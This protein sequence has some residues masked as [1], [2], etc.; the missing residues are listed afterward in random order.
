MLIGVDVGRCRADRKQPQVQTSLEGESGKLQSFHDC[1]N[2]MERVQCLAHKPKTF[3][4][5]I[6]VRVA[7]RNQMGNPESLSAVIGLMN[8]RDLMPF[9]PTGKVR[10]GKG[11]PKSP[12][13]NSKSLSAKLFGLMSRFVRPMCY[14]NL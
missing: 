13:T 2:D 8:K 10:S 1:E 5:P 14:E 4:S 7:P 3:L 11:V 9:R 12:K 6:K